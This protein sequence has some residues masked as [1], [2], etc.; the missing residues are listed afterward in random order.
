MVNREKRR[1]TL[2]STYEPNRLAKTHLLTAYEK[3]IPTIKYSLSSTKK[4]RLAIKDNVLSK[5]MGGKSSW[6]R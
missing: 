5:K 3:L 1:L 2:R 4:N 6:P